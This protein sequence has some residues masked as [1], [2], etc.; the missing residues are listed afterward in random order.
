METFVKI[1]QEWNGLTQLEEDVNKYAAKRNLEIISI[2][3]FYKKR[4]TNCDGFEAICFAVVYKKK[5]TEGEG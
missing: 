2:T 5:Y 3:S 4:I 1:F